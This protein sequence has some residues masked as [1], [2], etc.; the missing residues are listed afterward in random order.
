MFNKYFEDIASLYHLVEG[1]GGY[2]EVTG[3]NQWDSFKNPAFDE[4]LDASKRRSLKEFYQDYLFHYEKTH[5]SSHVIQTSLDNYNKTIERLD[6]GLL[7]GFQLIEDIDIYDENC[8]REVFKGKSCRFRGFLNGVVGFNNNMFSL[9]EIS[10]CYGEQEV[11][12]RCQNPDVYSFDI[13]GK[14]SKQN[15]KMF[16]IKQYIKY[17][18]DFNE[19]QVV[20]DSNNV[21]FAVNIDI[22]KWQNQ[23]NELHKLPKMMFCQTQFDALTYLNQPIEGVTSPQLYLKVKGCWTGGHEEN[24]R[25]QALNINHGN[26]INPIPIHISYIYRS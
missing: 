13:L 6:P 19:N 24:L 18:N 5:C 10:K 3:L 12:S 7:E 26:H 1:K 4:L 11:D 8:L 2:E 16:T 15:K 14:N 25:V 22:S 21:F 17:Q 23:L 9:E 20:K